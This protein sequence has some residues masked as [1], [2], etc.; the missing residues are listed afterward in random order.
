M[1]SRKVLDSSPPPR[2]QKMLSFTEPPRSG[3]VL[4]TYVPPTRNR[5]RRSL[6]GPKPSK[7]DEHCSRTVLRSLPQREI[8]SRR[9]SR[10]PQPSENYEHRIPKT[11]YKPT[12]NTKSKAA[13]V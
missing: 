13:E 12:P 4:Q 8:Q 10:W 1:Q 5:S 11:F 7:N 6:R 9:S 2:D 3:T